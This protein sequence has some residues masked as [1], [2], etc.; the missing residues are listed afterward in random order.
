MSKMPR[1]VGLCLGDHTQEFYIPDAL[2]GDKCP[3]CSSEILIYFPN[4][5]RTV[6]AGLDPTT[7]PEIDI[8]CGCIRTCGDMPEDCDHPNAICVGLPT[9]L[10]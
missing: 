7:T 9:L 10:K 4:I 8:P 5:G 6:V 1:Q 3:A 2:P